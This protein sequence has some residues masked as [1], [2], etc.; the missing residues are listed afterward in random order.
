[1][2]ILQATSFLE[3]TKSDTSG[4]SSITHD[5]EMIVKKKKKSNIT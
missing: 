2:V 3:G 4:T 1:M 5:F